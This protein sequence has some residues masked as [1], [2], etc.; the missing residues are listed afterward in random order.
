MT[1]NNI[2]TIVSILKVLLTIVATTLGVFLFTSW[3]ITA[4]IEFAYIMSFIWLGFCGFV[5]FQN[6]SNHIVDKKEA[7]I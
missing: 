2:K 3:M 5:I 1:R 7:K 4:N 6:F